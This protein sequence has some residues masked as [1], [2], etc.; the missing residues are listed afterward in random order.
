MYN[1]SHFQ[2]TETSSLHALMEAHPLGMLVTHS[3]QG[4]DANHLPFLL[5]RPAAAHA[6]DTAGTPEQGHTP[7]H[8]W[9]HVARANPL[10][11]QLVDGQPVLVVF[12]AEEAYIS[13]NWFPSKHA[14]HQQVPTWNYRV[15]HAHGRIRLRDDEAFVRGV[16]ARLTRM[17]EQQVQAALPHPAG[18]WKMG[19][20]EP[21][22]L[23]RML[24]AIVGIEVEVARLEGKFKLSQNRVPEDRAGA[25]AALQAL[26]Q[27]AMAGH[28][29][30]T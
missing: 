24:Q 26:G 23:Q 27:T 13:P 12:R 3:D 5:H 11:Q 30:P 4:L 22:Y 17:H 10:V 8:L 9:A 6:Q 2:V 16:V 28:M 29:A 15:V 14:T 7:L 18:A 25:A 1:P 21:A 19:D 20:A